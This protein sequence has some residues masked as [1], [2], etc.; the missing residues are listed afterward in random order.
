MCEWVRVSV[1]VCVCVWW[2]VDVGWTA[3]TVRPFHA[4]ITEPAGLFPIATLTEVKGYVPHIHPPPPPPPPSPPALRG[5]PG[6]LLTPTL[7]ADRLTNLNLSQT[8]K[9]E[10][11]TM[12]F[13][14]LALLFVHHL[15]K[16]TYT[17]IE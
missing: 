13:L 7:A 10:S 1:C 16:C 15:P 5:S 14:H 17:V 12:D 6:G 11:R 9:T 4:Y 8:H 2:G 3:L